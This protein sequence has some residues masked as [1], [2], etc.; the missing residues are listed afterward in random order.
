MTSKTT[1]LDQA[2][3]TGGQI[4]PLSLAQTTQLQK[5]MDRAAGFDMSTTYAEDFFRTSGQ[6]LAL[7]KVD[8]SGVSREP[9]LDAN[10]NGIAVRA[11]CDKP[12]I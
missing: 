3:G 7:Y 5:M 4:P 11:N 10:L 12:V 8:N 2:S 6:I 9:E 1:S